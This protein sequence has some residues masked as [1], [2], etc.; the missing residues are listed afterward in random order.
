MK[1]VSIKYKGDNRMKSLKGKI[2]LMNVIIS[3]V[4]ALAIGSIGI[5]DLS[6]N[7][8]K[9]IS[10]YETLLRNDYDSNIKNQVENVITLLD[11]I[12]KKQEDG[13]LTE[14][15]AKQEAKDLIKNL[16][17]NGEGYFWIDGIDATLIAHP[18][19]S[20]Q[21]GNNRIDETDKNGNKLIQNII[22]TATTNDEGGFNNFYFMKPG[23]DGVAP[24]RAY[25]KLFKPY[26]WIVSTGNYVDDIDNVVNEK[27]IELSSELNSTLQLLVGIMVILL[28]LAIIFAVKLSSNLTKPI[29]KIQGLAERLSNYD[30]SENLDIKDKTELGKTAEALNLAQSNIKN[31]IRSIREN[32]SELTASSEN[33]SSLTNRVKDKVNNMNAATKEIVENMSESS[34]SANQVNECMKEVSLSVDELS[35]RSTD[36][37]GISIN[38]KDKSLELKNQ[39]NSALDNTRNIYETKEQRIL[40][41]LKDGEVV[42][43]IAK[44]VQAISEISEQTNLLSLNAAIEAAR[45]G[46]EGKGFAVVAEEVRKLAEECSDS[47]LSI[48]D[49]VV[50]V[51]DAF[52]KLS[53]NSNEVLKFINND[54]V[55]NFNGFISSGEYYYENAERISSISEDIAAMS[56]ELNASVEEINAMIQTMAENSEKSAKNSNRILDEINETTASIEEVAVTAESQAANAQKLNELIDGFKIDK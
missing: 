43:E 9:H 29:I 34:E 25:S 42:G 52:K 26:G 38:F 53:D 48:Q 41:A 21:E 15:E 30:F 14:E 5:I 56:E 6:R 20:E 24:K 32:A 33:L 16:R 13:Q 8:A 49:I 36:G 46:E 23:E 31:L 19:L 7:N 27:K 3:I 39:T 35:S 55:K 1:T 28:I 18:I 10:D 4:I 17:Y 51:E 2:I 40:E 54:I 50:K 11:G 47:A 12:Y 37:S 45:A 22:K 44:M